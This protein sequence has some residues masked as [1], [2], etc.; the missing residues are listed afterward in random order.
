MSAWR[1]VAFNSAI[2]GAFFAMIIGGVFPDCF[3]EESGLT[4][5]KIWS[6]YAIIVLFGIGALGLYARREELGNPFAPL[7]IGSVIA[8]MLAE[9]AFTRYVSVYGLA[10]EIGHYFML[11]SAYL[12]YRAFI[13][14][15][16]A[17]PMDLLFDG[18]R[19]PDPNLNRLWLCA[20]VSWRNKPGGS[21]T[22]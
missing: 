4:P 17:R 13:I 3:V 11:I 10:N 9:V 1:V 18:L 19:R 5:F 8:G 12:L 21:M 2:T 16:I 22:F 6:E 7:L 20:P 15:G 14:N